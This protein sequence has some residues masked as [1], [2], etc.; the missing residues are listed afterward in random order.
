M[1]A[2]SLQEQL[3]GAG[4][5]DKKKAK[6][7]KAE[8]LQQK[9][10]VK[11]GKAVDDEKDKRQAELKQQR[12]DKLEKDRQLNLQRQKDIENKAIHGQ[13]RQMILQNRIAKEDGDIA[14]HFTDNKKVKQLYISQSMHNDLSGGRLAIAKLDAQYEIIPEPAAVKISERDDSYILVCNNRI[15]AVDDDPYAD[16]QIPDDLMW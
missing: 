3:L 4:I 15:E 12:D 2:K 8:K 9:Q 5:V 13:I 6:K 10:K 7:I 16:F 1:A 11:N 14:Y